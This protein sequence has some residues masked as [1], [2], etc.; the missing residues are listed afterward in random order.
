MSASP[1]PLSH[2]VTSHRWQS[3]F[4]ILVPAIEA[5]ARIKF[6]RLRPVEREEASAEALAR[7]CITYATLAR[8]QKLHRVFV[9]NVAT[10]AVRAV[11]GGRH[12]GG[13]QT[14]RDVLSALTHKK[15]GIAVSSLTPWDTQEGTWRE[16]AVETKRVSPADTA[17]F[18]LDFAAWRDRWPPRQRQI[19]D[20]L[21]AGTKAVAIARK[22]GLTDG[23]VSQLREA[24]RR[25]W[26]QY[27]SMPPFAA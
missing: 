20:L 16:V 8:Q 10:N 5:H 17:A 15:K 6:H 2:R 12:V 3:N 24:F 22:F 27:Q 25:S 21:A 4:L 26:E 7:A 14:S 18:R 11:N 1:V 9:G 23:R 13:R 19:I